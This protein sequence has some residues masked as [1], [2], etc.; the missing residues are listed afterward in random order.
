MNS[1]SVFSGMFMLLGLHTVMYEIIMILLK[2]HFS[3]AIS[4]NGVICFTL[5]WSWITH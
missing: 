2:V 5:L 1:L 4:Q 3:R